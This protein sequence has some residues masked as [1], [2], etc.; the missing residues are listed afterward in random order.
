MDYSGYNNKDIYGK[1]DNFMPEE[2]INKKPCEEC[3]EFEK[4]EHDKFEECCE[5]K[6]MPKK[7][8]VDEVLG[9]GEA[10]TNFEVCIPV[11]PPAF[12]ILE[13]LIKKTIEFDTLV[14]TD[15][16][17]FVNARLIKNIPFKTK[18][19]TVAPVCSGISKIV[20][21]DIR[22]VTV[23]I[24]FSLC[25]DI[26][27]AEKGAKVVVLDTD[28]NSVEIPHF[29]SCKC[30]IIKSITEKDCVRVK[31]KVVKDRILCVPTNEY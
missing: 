8:E 9:V 27:K 16:K 15:G 2:E 14:A 31:V 13:N 17:V 5:P 1:Y 26:P 21:G 18:Q 7:I 10:E 24:P 3:P 28:I 6:P 29:I 23:E 25:I 4:P 20:F 12:E 19:R 30:K 11:I 22:H